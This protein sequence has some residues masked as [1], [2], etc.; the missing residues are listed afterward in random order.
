MKTL[1]E[2]ILDLEACKDYNE[3]HTLETAFRFM[4]DLR[5]DALVLALHLKQLEVHVE[6]NTSADRRI[7][8]L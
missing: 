1:T 6:R 5:K 8:Q 4:E 7:G 2:V 3:N